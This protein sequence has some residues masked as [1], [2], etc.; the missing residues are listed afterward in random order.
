L[1]HLGT[2][3]SKDSISVAMLHPYRDVAEVDKIFSDAESVRRLLKR[4]GRR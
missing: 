3:V 1:V 4:V 2:D